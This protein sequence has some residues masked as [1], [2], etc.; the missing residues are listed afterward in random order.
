MRTLL[1]LSTIS[2]AQFCPAV[3]SANP[4]PCTQELAQ[5]ERMMSTTRPTAQQTVDS[6][7]HRQPT[8]QSIANAATKARA[9]VGALLV[10]A[11]MLDEEGNASDCMNIVSR[12]KSALGQ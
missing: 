2:I 5:I 3:A 11:K 7:L 6:Q 4:G 9:D 1:A 8:P 10:R 12:I